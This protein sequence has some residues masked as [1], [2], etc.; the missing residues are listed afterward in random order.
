[1]R[2]TDVLM[3]FQAQ[4]WGNPMST[5]ISCAKQIYT[6]TFETSFSKI[7]FP[8][9]Q[10]RKHIDYLH[11]Y[12]IW[13]KHIGKLTCNPQIP[14]PF[15]HIATSIGLLPPKELNTCKASRMASIKIQWL[16]LLV[17]AKVWGSFFGCKGSE[18]TTNFPTKFWGMSGMSKLPGNFLGQS[19]F[20]GVP[21]T[22]G[23]A[24]FFRLC[25]SFAVPIYSLGFEHRQVCLPDFYSTINSITLCIYV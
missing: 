16:L 22:L 2:R 8:I 4:K 21:V 1:M 7:F 10:F 14:T 12:I 13:G 19:N 18:K 6:S 24:V 3:K 17:A 5:N 25:A 11:K 23:Q 9:Q 20:W 15:Q